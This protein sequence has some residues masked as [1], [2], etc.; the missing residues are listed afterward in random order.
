M[1]PLL[2]EGE[3][4]VRDNNNNNNNNKKEEEEQI[5][6]APADKKKR[7]NERQKKKEVSGELLDDVG[8]DRCG[9]SPFPVRTF[10]SVFVSFSTLFDDIRHRSQTCCWA[11]TRH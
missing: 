11:T 1:V 4:E 8:V 3:E 5:V 7:K 6:R 9:V 2:C 10:R